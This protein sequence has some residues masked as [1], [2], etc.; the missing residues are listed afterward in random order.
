MTTLQDITLHQ[1]NTEQLLLT[2]T[3][4]DPTEDL[5]LITG[6]T[7]IIKDDPCVTDTATGVTTLTSA[8]PAQ[9]TITTQTS[10][11]IT[12]T[13]YLPAT[14]TASPYNR[15]WRCDAHVGTAYR[16]A[17]YGTVTVVDL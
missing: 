14:L 8:N 11:Q 1:G 12:A 7:V 5:T 13:A 2:I 9:I 16:T 17:I 4:V 3:R 6:L 15:W 10:S